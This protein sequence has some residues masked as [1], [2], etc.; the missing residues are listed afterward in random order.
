MSFLKQ[1]VKNAIG[2]LDGTGADFQALLEE[3]RAGKNRKVLVKWL[4][5]QD[6]QGRSVHA[7]GKTT[8]VVDTSAPEVEP[9]YV[10]PVV[11]EPPESPVVAVAGIDPL[12]SGEVSISDLIATLCQER[13]RLQ[14][15]TSCGVENIRVHISG[16][17]ISV[18]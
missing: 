7:D 3:E 10:E 4:E 8:R 13:D 17:K 18:R 9:V 6:A 12:G 16:I 2:E 5:K 1:S 14:R 15:S 11:E